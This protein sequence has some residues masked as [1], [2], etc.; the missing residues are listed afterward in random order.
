MKY[1]HCISITALLTTA[2]LGC[3]QDAKPAP[4][5]VASHVTAASPAKVVSAAPAPSQA[6]NVLAAPAAGC[7]TRPNL[8]AEVDVI[9]RDLTAIIAAVPVANDV[10]LRVKANLSGYVTRFLD[11]IIQNPPSANSLVTAKLERFSLI[12]ADLDATAALQITKDIDGALE[13]AADCILGP[14]VAT[15]PGARKQS[16]DE[17]SEA[18]LSTYTDDELREMLKK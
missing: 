7:G 17:R 11:A 8:F 4:P 12:V 15:P 13:R 6:G 2:S 18:I 16:F 5:T 1:A 9:D 3:T 10:R 14:R